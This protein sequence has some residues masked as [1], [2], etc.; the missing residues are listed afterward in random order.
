MSYIRCTSNPESLYIYSDVGGFISFTWK[1]DSGIHQEAECSPEDWQDFWSKLKNDEDLFDCLDDDEEIRAGTLAVRKTWYDRTNHV[2]LKTGNVDFQ[3][4]RNIDHLVELIVGGKSIF[5]YLTTWR[6]LA[7]NSLSEFRW[8]SASRGEKLSSAERIPVSAEASLK[9]VDY[10]I[11]TYENDTTKEIHEDELDKI[12]KSMHEFIEK[13]S[14]VRLAAI[15]D[16]FPDFKFDDDQYEK[17]SE[18]MKKVIDLHEQGKIDTALDSIYDAVDDAFKA[19]KFSLVD[20]MLIVMNHYN[21]KRIIDLDLA[22][23][24]TTSWAKSKLRY[25]RSFVRLVKK[26]WK[27]QNYP[28]YDRVFLNL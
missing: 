4:G 26:Y 19:G 13:I 25:R 20:H 9:D 21:S 16:D 15:N 24:T 18:I 23:I 17:A 27:D 7:E 11:L 6:Y 8:S 12:M 22:L 2:K 28:D 14:A 1:D 10:L 3:D 5:M